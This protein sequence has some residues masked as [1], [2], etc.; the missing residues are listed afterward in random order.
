MALEE[1]NI[2]RRFLHGAARELE[3]DID[4]L[5]RLLPS[6]PSGKVR[7]LAYAGYRNDR[8]LRLMGRIVRFAEALDPRDT[9][10]S[11]IRAMLA[12]YNSHEV[13]GVAVRLDHEGGSAE[14][15]SDEEGYFS[16][17]IPVP[18]PLPPVT[19]WESVQLSTPE[20]EMQAPSA[21][22]PVLAPGTDD[23][24]GVISDID[25][26]VIET[27]ATSLIKNWRRVIA[28]RPSDRLVVPGAASL[29]GLIAG[30]QKAPIRPFFY[31]TS[32]PW[33]LYGFLAEFMEL[34][35]IP[36]GPMFMKDIG[37]DETKFIK[38]GHGEHKLDA[39]KTI[40][41]FYPGHR[42]LLMGDNGQKDVEIYAEAVRTYPG[43]VGAV[44]IRD[45]SGTC[46]TGPNAE[47]LAEI[48][49]AGIPTYCAA[50]FAEAQ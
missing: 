38:S 1:S 39:I 10:I 30:D 5:R 31:V 18:R 32:S 2:F 8:E 27:G 12:I 14:T 25:D 29:Y 45:V 4:R 11:R 20:R 34:N 17:A 15:R 41:A 36:H 21:P 37:I 48:G 7:M 26:T 35:G 33:N 6:R 19:L 49:R 3:N 47:H 24:W 23:H 13:P 44:L 16:F 40:L 28:E 50:D 46:R 22:V 42:F 43:R 9:M